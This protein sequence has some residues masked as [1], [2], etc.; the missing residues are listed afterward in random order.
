MNLA[1]CIKGHA[2]KISE[3]K[4]CTLVKCWYCND[5]VIQGN[6]CQSCATRLPKLANDPCNRALL[7]DII[8]K[9]ESDLIYIESNPPSEQ[10]MKLNPGM[11]GRAIHNIQTK[12]Y[13]L[14]KKLESLG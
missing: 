2:K 10:L 9:L 12:I 5:F 1:V 14:R 8:S 13:E 6:F 7:H 4:D 3:E 11:Y